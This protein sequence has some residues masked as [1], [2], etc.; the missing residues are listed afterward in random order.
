MKITEI[1]WR[2]FG[3]PGERVKAMCSIVLDN[4]LV[5]HEVRVIKGRQRL[6]V[7]YPN[8]AYDKSDKNGCVYPIDNDLRRAWEKEILASFVAAIK[9]DAS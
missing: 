8:K 9:E 3:E 4:V 5:I 6:F 2:Q 7:A 1:N